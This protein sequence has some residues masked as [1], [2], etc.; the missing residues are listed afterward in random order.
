M[1]R[2]HLCTTVPSRSF[3][4]LSSK[5]LVSTGPSDAKTRGAFTH[6]EARSKFQRL[7]TRKLVKS[8]HLSCKTTGHV[9]E[10]REVA[11]NADVFCC[12]LVDESSSLISA[13]LSPIWQFHRILQVPEN[14]SIYN[15]HVS[16]ITPSKIA[17][18]AQAQLWRI[19]KALPRGGKRKRR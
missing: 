4:T 6:I 17:Q 5:R 16:V 7:W 19:Y 2:S 10:L 13:H 14:G 15:M 1:A 9:L 12:V 8:L 18:A 3:G 11:P